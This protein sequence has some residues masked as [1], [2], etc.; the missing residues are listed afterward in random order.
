M[1][2]LSSDV[3]QSGS[4]LF[5][6]V[7]FLSCVYEM[8]TTC[9]EHGVLSVESNGHCQHCDS[10]KDGEVLGKLYKIR[11][12][13]LKRTKYKEF[14]NDFNLPALLKY[15]WYRFYMTILGKRHIV[16]TGSTL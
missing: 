14:F 1:P 4:D 3:S 16:G 13:V 8:V 5:K 7:D 10:K 9:T 15:R 12:L 2:T 6:Q 11:Q